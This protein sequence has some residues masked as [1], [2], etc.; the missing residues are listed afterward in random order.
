LHP[1]ATSTDILSRPFWPLTA[2]KNGHYGRILFSS[3]TFTA[4]IVLI[5]QDVLLWHAHC[6]IF[7]K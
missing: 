7:L 4:Y 3:Q 6:F 2:D 5:L 1:V